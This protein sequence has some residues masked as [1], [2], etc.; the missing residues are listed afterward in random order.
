MSY[1]S[2]VEVTF[3]YGHCPSAEGLVVSY[4]KCNMTDTNSLKKIIGSGVKV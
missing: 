2:V 4:V 3:T 1:K